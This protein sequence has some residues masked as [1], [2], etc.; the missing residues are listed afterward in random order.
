MSIYPDK[1]HGT[2][3]GRW[4][5]AVQ[6]EGKR[7]R[8]RVATRAEAEAI[9]AEFSGAFISGQGM[10]KATLASATSAN[11]VYLSQLRKRVIQRVWAGKGD[12]QMTTLRSQ[13]VVDLL[14]DPKLADINHQHIDLLVDAYAA[15]G[16]KGST[17]NRKLSIFHKM[18]A[19]AC[20]REWIDK[21]P[22]FE[23]HN[24]SEGRIRWLEDDE[25]D[26][27][28]EYFKG[29]EPRMV[30]VTVVAIDTGMRRGELLSL[31]PTQVK[32]GWVHLWKTK[33]KTPRSVSLTDR[34][35]DVLRAKAS[36]DDFTIT[37]LRY[38]WDN[39]RK[40]LGLPDVVF[41][42]CRHTC[43][44]RLV[45]A[46]VNLRVIQTYMGHKNIQTTLRYAHVNDGMIEE[47][48]R[49][50]TQRRVM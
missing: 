28:I 19:F 21:V 5:V 49:K 6:Q 42:C 43:A 50:L 40:D 33:T 46:N 23:W 26:Q 20:K 31:E 16:N 1:K 25:E 47:A 24:E 7:L 44:T 22:P 15:K 18:L 48:A 8:K 41:Y 35:H 39:M 2:F 12:E 30:D 27:I 14:G 37:R 3:T 38:L 4:V 10:D 34:A 29:V 9:E 45:Q 36:F 32:N 17:I 13:E 11:P